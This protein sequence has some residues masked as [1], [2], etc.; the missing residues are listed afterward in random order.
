MSKPV[1]DIEARTR[2]LSPDQSFIIQAPAGSGK[3]GLLIQRYLRLLALVDAPEEII[4]ITFTRKAAAEMQSRILEAL[5]N[6]LLNKEPKTDHEKV[7]FDLAVA[8]LKRDQEKGWQICDNP[9]RLRLQ[10]IDSLCASLTRQMPMLAKLGTQPETLEDAE[11]LYQQAAINTLAGLESGEGWSDVIA[12][13]VFHLDNDLPRIKNLIVDMLRKRDQWLQHVVLE[14]ERDQMEQA[15]V[16]LI[17]DQL[18]I[19]KNKFP[20]QFESELVELIRFAAKNL[21]ESDPGNPVSLCHSLSSIP[22]SSAESLSYWCGIGELLLTRTGTWRKQFTVKNGFPPASGNKLEADERNARKKQIQGLLIALQ[23]IEGLQQALAKVSSLPPAKYSDSEWLIVNALCELLMIA[24]AQLRLIFAERNQMDFIGIAAS[25]VEALGTDDA[26]TELALSMDYHIK[27]LLVDEYQDI[28][29]SQYRLLQRLTREWSMDDGRSL[30]LVGDP[31]QSIYRFR[32]AEVAL[33]IKTFHEKS[34]GNIPLEALKL[35]VNFRSQ[36]NL[37]EWVNHSFKSI[38]PKQDD[39]ITSAVSYSEA[40]AFDKSV[41]SNNV[42]IVPQYGRSYK[43][44]SQNLV[45]IVKEIKQKNQDDNIAIL[46][47]SRSH[48]AEVIPALRKEK[49]AFQ[50]IDIEGLGTQAS[51][52]DLLALTRAF[53]YPADRVAWLACLRAAWCGLNLKSLFLLCDNN[54]DK[55][56]WECVCDL[57][58]INQLEADEQVRLQNFKVKFETISAQKQRFS[59]RDSIESLWIQLGGPASLSNKIELENC[60]TY[61]SLLENLDQG[62][63]IEDLKELLDNV[64]Q[65]YAAPDLKEDGQLQVMTIH[66]AKGL[67]FDHVILPGLGRSPRATQGDLLVW[68]L[69]QRENQKEDLVLAPIREAGHFQA[70]LYDFINNTDKAKQGY[71]DARL[72][73][74]ATTRTKKTLHLLGHASVKEKK[75]EILCDAQN[76]SLLG[77]LWPTLKSVYEQHMPASIE[78]SE[79]ESAVVINQETKRLKKTWQ[80]PEAPAAIQW[81]NSAADEIQTEQVL[82]EFEWAGETIKHIG[83]VVHGAIQCMAE[84][85]L[86]K[87]TS[88]YIYT[89]QQSFDTALKQFGV[90]QDERKEAV[91]R[92]VDALINMINDERGQWI[93]SN[94]HNKQQNEYA[95]TGVVDNK[96]TNAILDRTFID[97]EGIRWIIDYKTSRHEGKNIDAFLNHEQERYQEQLE[98][99][100]SL[101]RQIGNENIK[102]G[103]YFPLLQGWR[104]WDYRSGKE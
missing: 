85:G 33:F 103:L 78:Q 4:A 56:V 96:I 57:D 91:E 38:F 6:V 55:T 37:V 89:E 61:F 16:R 25:A 58:L 72:L 13:L 99:Y 67:E 90:P 87:W 43:R 24:A 80:L 27:H 79:E 34:L 94:K 71:E 39:L 11:P 2:A 93:L 100:A 54:K 41:S 65:L 44:E 21:N 45:D 12:N 88:E 20:N 92:V 40:V 28:S 26:P 74:V 18:S 35:S 50:A 5:D 101:L 70:P 17:E 84:E 10:T 98:K 51:I 15:L 53:L 95:I 29:V 22:D 86:G 76:R 7:T 77:Y 102:L 83:S 1:A 9:G 19:V 59:L 64:S 81:H 66:K 75:D 69:R 30:F 36:Q 46:V 49:I 73:Y 62:G 31:M 68:L 14:H 52:Q 8:A 47:R 104:E 32:Q 63:T 82:I 3:T 48:L 60:A 42:K 23:K 97:E